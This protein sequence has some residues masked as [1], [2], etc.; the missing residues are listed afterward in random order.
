LLQGETSIDLM[1]KGFNNSEVLRRC[2]KRTL[3]TSSKIEIIGIDETSRATGSRGGGVRVYTT[4][5]L[6]AMTQSKTKFNKITIEPFKLTGLYYASDEILSDAGMLQQEMSGLFQEEFSFKVQD[7]VIRGSGAGEAL[8]IL[9]AGCLVSQAKETGQAAATVVTE[10]LI[11]M[12]ARVFQRNRANLV[13]LINQDVEPQL[14]TL[15][16]PVGTGG[17]AYQAYTP[18]GANGSAYGSILGIPCI[19]IEQCETVGTV[20]DIILA[21]FSQYYVADKGAMNS[22]SSIHLKFDYNQTTFRFIYRI[23][24][25]PRWESALTPYKGGS[26]KTIS[27]FVALATRS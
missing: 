9:N 21:D 5:E 24:G 26:S 15:V 25:Q 20:G 19:P 17:V 11:N 16:L 18:P 6:D 23:D 4:A 7:L 1:T 22:A 3:T 2:A 13:F 8:G 10:N 12:K 27:P 14:Y